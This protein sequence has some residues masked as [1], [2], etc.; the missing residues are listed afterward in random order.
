MWQKDTIM[1]EEACMSDDNASAS[2]PP[3][4]STIP[5]R[6]Y[7]PYSKAYLETPLWSLILRPLCLDCIE[8]VLMRLYQLRA[9]ISTPM[10]TKVIPRVIAKVLPNRIAFITVGDL[11][12]LVPLLVFFLRG[13]HYTFVSPALDLSGYMAAS[14]L[15]YTFI[16]ASKS[17]SPFSFFLGIPYER[18]IGLHW[19]SAFCAAFLSCCHGY[20]AYNY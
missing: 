9:F 17:N 6:S 10:S 7:K 16:T 14:C 2:L 12:L 15:Y 19:A 3:Q 5:P 20:V 11:I 4:G 13:L 1:S 18:L 8:P